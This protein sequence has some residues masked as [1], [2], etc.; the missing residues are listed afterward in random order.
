MNNSME[1]VVG[2]VA[3]T[4]Y[5]TQGSTL[6]DHFARVRD[7]NLAELRQYTCLLNLSLMLME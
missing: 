4:V 6:V 5:D 1:C 2:K 7:W 3:I